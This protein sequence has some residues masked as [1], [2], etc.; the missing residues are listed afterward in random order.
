MRRPW[1]RARDLGLARCRARRGSPIAGPRR[2]LSPAVR[3]VPGRRRVAP[4]ART[5]SPGPGGNRRH[6]A[7]S[8]QRHRR[9]GRHAGAARDRSRSVDPAPTRR[10][11]H[12]ATRPAC[13]RRAAR[14]SKTRGN[15]D[16]AFERVVVRASFG[17]D[18]RARQRARALS[19]DAS[20]AG[21]ERA[22]RDRTISAWLARAVTIYPTGYCRVARRAFGATATD[23]AV[24]GFS[25]VLRVVAGADFAPRRS[26]VSR[27]CAALSATAPFRARTLGGCRILPDRDAALICRE[28]RAIGPAIPL[29]PTADGTVLKWDRRFRVN[30]PPDFGAGYRGEMSIR[31][32]GREGRLRIRQMP[33]A[34]R[35]TGM[36]RPV[37][38]ALPALWHLDAVVE[39]PHL[40]LE[41]TWSAVAGSSCFSAVFW[42]TPALAEAPFAYAAP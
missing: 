28:P 25:R 12:A 32:L 42:T 26:A 13:R 34:Q 5:P 30:V 20:R 18:A 19:D 17:S 16:P 41:T 22:E 6:A 4:G 29:K 3:M 2:P 35:F 40:P 9:T 37:V 8:E 27:I 14:G 1:H 23:I 38:E 31:A 33:C 24:A 10:R 11:S 36:P 21:A 15:H 39:L 7:R